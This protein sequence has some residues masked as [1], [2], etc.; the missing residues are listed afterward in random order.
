MF[1]LRDAGL[2]AEPAREAPATA[3][4]L[5]PGAEPPGDLLLHRLLQRLDPRLAARSL[6]TSRGTPAH[7]VVSFFEPFRSFSRV[8]DSFRCILPCGNSFR[9]PFQ[10]GRMLLSQRLKAPA[11]VRRCSE[12]LP[13]RG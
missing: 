6:G 7:D 10:G 4:Q 12:T 11:H 13:L 9:G 2:Q 3:L 5:R 8:L 1:L